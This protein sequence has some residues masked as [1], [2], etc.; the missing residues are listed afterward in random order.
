LTPP[1]GAAKLGA[2]MTRIPNAGKSIVFAFV[3]RIRLR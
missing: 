3:A 2:S 1:A